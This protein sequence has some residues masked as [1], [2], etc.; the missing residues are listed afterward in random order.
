MTNSTGDTQWGANGTSVCNATSLQVVP[1][2]CIDGAGGAIITWYDARAGGVG[3]Y[4]IYAQ[5]IDSTGNG[6]WGDNGT[7][8]CTSDGDTTNPQIVAGNNGSAIIAWADKRSG[9][10]IYAQL[11]NASGDGQWG[12]NGTAVVTAA[13]S[14]NQFGICSDGNGG[15]IIAWRD[16]RA[17]GNGLEI[18]A[19][20][21]N[22]SGDPQWTVDGIPICTADY[23]QEVP[24][25]VSDGAKGAIIVWRDERE[26]NQ[27]DDIYVQRI[28]PVGIPQW[29]A[30]GTIISDQISNQDPDFE[31]VSDGSG[32][33]IIVWE[34]NVGSDDIYG[35]RVTA[36]G[37]KIWG[38]NGKV[39]CNL[40]G[41]FQLN[42]VVCSDGVGGAIV[43]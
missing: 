10:H 40:A 39:L 18:Y 20:S 33:V 21:I 41:S 43:A 9:T 31:I 4:D 42:P 32:G 29:G 15:A 14:Q 3:F 13:N 12:G 24:L 1:K 11:V 19:Q 25:V 16:S 8:V 30:N 38:T 22:S 27:F 37:A 35:Q 26:D 17:G 5:R 2:L 6:L 23:D 36:S 34:V 28:D 7:E